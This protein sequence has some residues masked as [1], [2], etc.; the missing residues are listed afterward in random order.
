MV[1]SCMMDGPEC[2]GDLRGE[3]LLAARKATTFYHTE[4]AYKGGYL[5][6]YSADLSLRE[7]EGKQTK[8]TVWI[9]PPGTPAMGEAY[10]RL[11]MATGDALFLEA[12][13]ATADTLRLGQLR[14]GGWNNGIDFAPDQRVRYAYRVEPLRRKARDVSS[15]DDDK[16]QSC[17]RFLI[18]LDRATKF[19][20]PA[21]HEMVTYALD[22]L[23][24][25]Q[26]PNGAFPQ[27]WDAT[28]REGTFPA[29][30]ASYPDSY[31]RSYRGH[32]QYW[33]RYTLND[34]LM[35]DVM[36]VLF[37]AEDVYGDPRYRAAA[38][39]AA[40]FLLLAQLPEPQPAWAQQYDFEMQPIWARKF[41]PP[42]VSGGESQGILRLLMEYYRRTGNR[43]YLKPIPPA[44]TYLQ[45]S[46]LPDGQ[47]ARFYEL[48]TN[49]PLYFD[50]E[51]VLTYDDANTPTHYGFKVSSKLRGIADEYQELIAT[52][53]DELKPTWNRWRTVRDR[54]IQRIIDTLDPRG[55]WV[56]DDELR[57]QP[58]QGPIL[59][60]QDAV[61]NLNA[62]ADFLQSQRDGNDSS[63]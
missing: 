30:P 34:N 58:Y 42:A 7:G 50:R 54:E 32:Q 55:G 36:S 44:L 48:Q 1:L 22:A 12:A 10:T 57:F 52:P 14:S 11:Y 49:R 63:N 56:S 2:K 18:Q 62:L 40:R 21:V 4:V 13:K 27:V 46:L 6:R 33:Y 39:K 47:L 29:L 9:Q 53:A 59:N 8:T 37:L 16:T 19:R 28:P 45:R 38:E 51:Y 20:D 17:L 15:L 23:L 41:E 25:A 24:R 5:W 61:K 31:S 3:A 26:Y 35:P 60:M 43:Q